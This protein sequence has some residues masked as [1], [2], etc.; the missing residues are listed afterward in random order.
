MSRRVEE[1][2]D[3]PGTWVFDA[4]RA[5]KGYHLNAFLYSLMKPENRAEFKAD[6]RK[7]LMKFPMSE[8]QREA[9]L[10]R[11]WNRLLELGGVS[12]A[13]AKLA[14]TDGKSYQYMASQMVGVPE[15][16]YVKMM[17]SGGRKPDGWRSKSERNV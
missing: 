5:R 9:V 3:I 8:E 1:Y 17:L 2:E 14:F 15:E 11:D 12:Y 6:E 13:L 7:Y 4:Q 10:K 16:E